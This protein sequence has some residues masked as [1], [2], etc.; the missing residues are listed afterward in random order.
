MENKSEIHK[1]HRSR[2]KTT[3]LKSGFSGFSD[4]DR[5][6]GTSEGFLKIIQECLEC[7]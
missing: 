5:L 6:R 7:V 2:M 1:N 4:I 3:Y